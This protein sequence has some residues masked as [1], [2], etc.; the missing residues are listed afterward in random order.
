[1]KSTKEN[2]RAAEKTV[3]G[4]TTE[5]PAVPD[6]HS[7]D[8]QLHQGYI[9][10]LFCQSTGRALVP[11]LVTR[12]TAEEEYVA[13][14]TDRG[15]LNIT[16][17]NRQENKFLELKYRLTTSAPIVARPAYLPP[18]PKVTGDSGLIL[19]VSGDGFVYAIRE[20][21]GESVWRF[22]TGEPIVTAPVVID[23]RLYVVT[24]LGGMHCL[25]AETGKE[26][27]W[28]PNVTQFVAASKSRIY[29]LDRVG[30]ILVLNAQNGARLDSLATE[31]IPF[32]LV[33]DETDRIYVADAGG[34]IQCLHEVEQAQPLVHGLER[35]QAAAEE[36]PVEEKA[37]KKP[38]A[39][40]DAPAA[41]E[42]KAKKPAK[43]AVEAAEDGNP[44]GQ[45]ADA[46]RRCRGGRK[47][48]GRKGQEGQSQGGRRAVTPPAFVVPP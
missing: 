21:D 12:E 22:S 39:K 25:E 34:L 9:P 5:Q 4:D 37:E 26:L 8:V 16:R 43:K 1:M 31:S 3:E 42:P 40:K 32:K 27:W 11:P 13:W 2:G 20:R 29:T 7:K 14:S 47:S 30:R 19:A 15:Y 41:K 36:K 35:K 23:D 28:T 6:E 45:G 18:D 38:G 48:Q 44:F 17:L 10:P 46:R 24:Q 33:N